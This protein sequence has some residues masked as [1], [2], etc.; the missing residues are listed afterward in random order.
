M[1]PEMDGVEAA[2]LIRKM[3]HERCR[4]MPIV[5]L[6]ANAVGD[7]RTMFLESG[8]NDFLSKP[9][10]VKELERCLRDWLPREKWVGKE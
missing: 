8:M 1:M 6:T 7:V 9:L 4:A 2:V 5:A 10:I 3:P